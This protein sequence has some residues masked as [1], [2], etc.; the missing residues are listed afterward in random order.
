MKWS[1]VSFQIPDSPSSIHVH[2]VVHVNTEIDLSN[3]NRYN[4]RL[5][6]SQRPLL[7]LITSTVNCTMHPPSIL[8]YEPSTP[9]PHE[10]PE[11]DM[12][13]TRCQ[14]AFEGVSSIR[15]C[16]LC[17]HDFCSA[18]IAITSG[19]FADSPHPSEEQICMNCY[20]RKGN[21]IPAPVTS[22]T[23]SFLNTRLS[24]RLEGGNFHLTIEKPQS[25]RASR[26]ITTG[27]RVVASCKLVWWC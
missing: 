14:N 1:E 13:C 2:V 4:Y 9:V 26:I 5:Q 17:S 27:R 7:H 3:T 11:D 15:S 20:G 10:S 12:R 23:S 25:R 24:E 8:P 6:T 16:Y 19:K 18:C 21:T 22:Y